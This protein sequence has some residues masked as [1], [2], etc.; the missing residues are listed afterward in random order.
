MR[1]EGVTKYFVGT[2]LIASEAD[3]SALFP[4]ASRAMNWA[5]DAIM[6]FEKIIEISVGTDYALLQIDADRLMM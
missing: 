6:L 1:Y 3:L 2:R 4:R 5:V